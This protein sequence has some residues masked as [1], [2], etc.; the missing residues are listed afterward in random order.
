MA[1]HQ[2]YR[3]HHDWLTSADGDRIA[4]PDGMLPALVDL[5]VGLSGG[6]AD[7]VVLDAVDIAAACSAVSAGSSLNTS[8]CLLPSGERFKLIVRPRTTSTR[9]AAA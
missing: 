7:A 3:M 6:G 9:F 4:L 8:K 1:A 5:T 2:W